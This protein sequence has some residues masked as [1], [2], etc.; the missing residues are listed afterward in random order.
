MSKQIGGNLPL[1]FNSNK[2]ENLKNYRIYG[3]AEGVGEEVVMI[4][5]QTTIEDASE[6]QL[7]LRVTATTNDQSI[8]ISTTGIIAC[9]GESVP[10]AG[11]T[12]ES[13]AASSNIVDI[14]LDGTSVS[15]TATDTK[16]GVHYRGYCVLSDGTVL[17]NDIIST[18]LE[19]EQQQLSSDSVTHYKIP[20]LCSHKNL[21][22]GTI[23]NAS[24]NSSGVV[25]TNSTFDLAITPIE[26]G[27]SYSIKFSYP[28]GSTSKVFCGIFSSYP[29]IGS[30]T[31]NNTRFTFA[32]DY[33]TFTAP[34]SG[35][36]ASTFILPTDA[37]VFEGSVPYQSNYDLFIGSSQLVEDEYL[38]YESGKMYKKKPNLVSDII[39]NAYVNSSGVFTTNSS[40]N[41]AITL[42]EKNKMYTVLKA[43][44]GGNIFCGF[45]ETYP[46]M[47]ASTYDSSRLI[48]GTEYYTFI[49]PITGYL[50]SSCSPNENDPIVYEGEYP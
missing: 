15:T 33:Y 37:V 5:S 42:I 38:D 3:T 23:S 49:A 1:T 4:I 22:A 31:Y 48:F 36:L 13:A 18:T 8:I 45:F 46:A 6:R 19:Q 21:V 17:Y 25:V 14:S 35:Y 34:I 28:E 41:A 43:R 50:V 10:E 24:V 16:G 47:G 2:E 26:S 32:S 11:L 9:R 12:I 40:L 29:D 27:K 7:R 20:F 30:S 44:T 39:D